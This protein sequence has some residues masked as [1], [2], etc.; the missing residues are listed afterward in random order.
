MCTTRG[1]TRCPLD[2]YS[3][4]MLEGVGSATGKYV[5]NKI[6]L[7]RTKL[8][9][10]VMNKALPV[11]N[12]ALSVINKALPLINKALPVMNKALSASS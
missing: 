7:W 1:V 10:T 9:V 5:T 2:Y 11:I 3:E 12:K 4:L 6:A 8:P